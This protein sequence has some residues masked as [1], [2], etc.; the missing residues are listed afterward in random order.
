[1]LPVSR[2]SI[3]VLTVCPLLPTV[4][5]AHAQG[6]DASPRQI[7][8]WLSGGYG[9]GTAKQFESAEEAFTLSGSVQWKSM[10]LSARV[11]IVSEALSRSGTVDD[12]GV[13]V[14]LATIPNKPF[15]V[16]AAIW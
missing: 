7:T 6:Q 10:L 16:S 15:H 1:M 2:F 3:L 5:R 13:L 4:L 11:A 9:L 12:Y 14:G 8:F